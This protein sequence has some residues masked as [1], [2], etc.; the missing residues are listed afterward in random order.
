MPCSDGVPGGAESLC[1]T[2]SQQGL[3]NQGQRQTRSCKYMKLKEIIKKSVFNWEE[4]GS[5][6]KCE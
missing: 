3:G 2:Q 1:H 6:T 5:D 4:I